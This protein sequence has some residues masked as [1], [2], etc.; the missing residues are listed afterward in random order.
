MRFPIR[1]ALPILIVMPIFAA[2][3]LGSW[4]S[5]Q[6][7]QEVVRELAAEMS[8]KAT[9]SI[10]RHIDNHLAEAKILYQTMIAILKDNASILNSPSS[11]TLEDTIWNL[12]QQPD[13][14]KRVFF[15]NTRGDYLGF[16][17]AND[18]SWTIQIRNED[19]VPNRLTY[20]LD[21]Q[22]NPT[23]LV[24][25]QVYDP[26]VRVWYENAVEAGEFIWSPVYAFAS[27]PTL[28]VTAAQPIYT[29]EGE[30]QGV[31]G[32]D[33][34][35]ASL[36]YFLENLEISPSGDAFVMERS[37]ELIATSMNAE[38]FNMIDQQKQR[39]L[40][41]E[42]NNAL[43]RDIAAQL[44]D[45]M[46]NFSTITTSKEFVLKVAGMDQYIGV[47]TILDPAGIDWIVVVIVP[48]TDFN[49]ITMA[50]LHSTIQVGFLMAIGTGLMGIL[51]ARWITQ[52]IVRLTRAACQIE[53]EKFDAAI[54]TPVVRRDD[55]L[56]RLARIF[57]DM[58]RVVSSRQ[59]SLQQ[60]LQHLQQEH[61]QQS[62]RNAQLTHMG[63]VTAWQTLVSQSR[64][65]RNTIAIAQ[66]PNLVER[67]QT[68]SYFQNFTLEQ[69]Q[70]LLEFGEERWVT[71]GTDICRAGDD[72]HELYFLL[73]GKAEVLTD[74]D[75][76]RYLTSIQAGEVVGEFALLLNV[77]RVATVKAITPAAL[78]VVDRHGLR[79]LLTEYPNLE[80]RILDTLKKRQAN[81]QPLSQNLTVI[82]DPGTDSQQHYLEW[83]R[84]RL[85]QLLSG[86]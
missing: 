83:V 43:I 28:G 65:I 39:I 50:S 11:G 38:L 36:G 17:E 30:L 58:A 6:S 22:R 60:Q 78:F 73:D 14:P 72:G 42:S 59:Q 64:S 29:P 56:G 35:L 27:E 45:E 54:L 53:G 15:S 37:G 51:V 82:Q 10:E 81:R 2:V 33:E 61:A 69:R 67:I 8:R 85:R 84:S 55:E 20:R 25:S 26:R 48:S 63:N 3:G 71:I 68:I 31:F 24:Q 34:S 62:L 40:A 70:R 41:T 44:L 46:G 32:L 74:E 80:D 12:V 7:E 75:P 13:L 16:S 4:F 86:H 21:E 18:G 9:G 49:S 47:N 77:P 66:S 79:Q 52:P 19:T 57:Q 76:P 1:V 23:E 5:Y